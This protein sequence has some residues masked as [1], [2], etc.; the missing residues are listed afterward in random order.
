M[1]VQLPY[2]EIIIGIQS[3]LELKKQLLHAIQGL[4]AREKEILQMK[5][6]DDLDY[7][8]IAER[9]H[10]TKRT[11]YNI[12]H[13]ALKRLKKELSKNGLNVAELYPLLTMILPYLLAS[14]IV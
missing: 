9:C 4:S 10:I 12:I 1:D 5:F 6:Y 11:A 2:E 3:N 8:D 13:G 14:L 7:D